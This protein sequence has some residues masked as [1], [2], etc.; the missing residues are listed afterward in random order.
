MFELIMTTVN[1]FAFSS[2]QD[3]VNCSFY[4]KTGACRFGERW[5]TFWPPYL[6]ESLTRTNIYVFKL[7]VPIK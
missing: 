3:T 5:P 6:K 2:M 1:Y 7:Q 4:L